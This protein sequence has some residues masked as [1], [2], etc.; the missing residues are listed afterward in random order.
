MSKAITRRLTRLTYVGGIVKEEM[1]HLGIVGNILS[2]IGGQP[3]IYGKETT[4]TY[5][6][7]L[8]Y[9]DKRIQ[10]ELKRASEE[11]IK[12]FVAV[13]TVSVPALQ[14]RAHRVLLGRGTCPKSEYAAAARSSHCAGCGKC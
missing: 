9:D 12:L 14:L 4:P 2:A 7:P 1:L 5:P 11:Q 6:E 3:H 13:R 8:F 10:M